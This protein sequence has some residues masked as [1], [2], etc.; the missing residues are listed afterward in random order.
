MLS[1][2]DIV[3]LEFPYTNQA[4]SKMRPGLV[5][6]I[7]SQHQQEDVNVAYIT[8]ELDSYLYDP[9]ALLITA[10]DMVQGTLKHDTF[11]NI[12]L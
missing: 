12:I 4:G 8:S 3:L 5:L 1:Q 7:S 2:G 10:E 6:S 9:S 11:S